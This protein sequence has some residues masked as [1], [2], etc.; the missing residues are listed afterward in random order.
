MT[1]PVHA[2]VL[3][4]GAGRRLGGPKAALRLKGQ[5][6][7]PT[8][9]RNLR[10]G[11]ADKVWLVLSAAA[12]DAIADLGDPGADREVI[13]P[14]PDAGRTSSIQQAWR[15]CPADAAVLI[16]PCD[17]PLLQTSSCAAVMQAWQRHGSDPRA[18]IRPI[19]AGRRGGHPLLIGPAWRDEWLASDPDRPLREI[20]HADLAVRHDVLLTDP[21]AFFD[22]DTPEQLALVE[23]MLEA[24]PES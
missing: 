11:G 23:S 17:M 2:I 24:E 10:Q 20:L 1:A 4:A 19:S 13:N 3:A 14:H 8:L 9:I 6:M 12:L 5:W 22:V 16:H 18:V 15:Q 21:G 7:L